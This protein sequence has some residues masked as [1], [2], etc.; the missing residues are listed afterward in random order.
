M[1][2]LIIKAYRSQFLH[3]PEVFLD[4]DLH[5]WW[6]LL[7]SC[8]VG[9]NVCQCSMRQ[10]PGLGRREKSAT[11][12]TAWQHWHCHWNLTVSD[13][14]RRRQT[15]SMLWSR[16]TPTDQTVYLFK[17]FINHIKPRIWS[18]NARTYWLPKQR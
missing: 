16:K 6:L 5:L 14:T 1:N 3:R 8:H 4:A 2:K 11:L 10:W 17:H 9:S 15:R 13:T 12:P 7:A 18:M